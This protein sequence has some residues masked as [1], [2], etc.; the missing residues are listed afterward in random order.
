MTKAVTQC[1]GLARLIQCHLL[2]SEGLNPDLVFI[3]CT[4]RNHPIHALGSFA[5]LGLDTG[6]IGQDSSFLPHKEHC[7]VSDFT[8][9]LNSC[10]SH[11]V[12]ES[13]MR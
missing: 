2:A 12:W 9:T 11:R 10:L 1:K 6:S 8:L 4:T 5:V 13:S 3:N 7:L